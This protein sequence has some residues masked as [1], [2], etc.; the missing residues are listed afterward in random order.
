[1]HGK[2]RVSLREFW[3]PGSRR[4]GAVYGMY[5]LALVLF[6]AIIVFGFMRGTVG[7]DSVSLSTSGLYKTGVTSDG[8]T[9]RTSGYDTHYAV[10][11]V[12]NDGGYYPTCQTLSALPTPATIVKEYGGKAGTQSNNAHPWTAFGSASWISLDKNGNGREDSSTSCV[13][14]SDWTKKSICGNPVKVA[15]TKIACWAPTWN[16]WHYEATQKFSV[17]ANDNIDTSTVK[18]NIKGSV[19]NQLA[20]MINGVYLTT[21]S[22]AVIPMTDAA[23]GSSNWSDPNYHTGN[24]FT[25]DVPNNI[26]KIGQGAVNSIDFYVRSGYDLE[27]FVITDISL[28]ASTKPGG[29]PTNPPPATSDC[30]G[31]PTINTSTDVTVDLPD[32]TP[33]NSAA[34]SSATKP[35]ST[36]IQ[37][38]SE[39]TTTVTGVTDISSGGNPVGIPHKNDKYGQTT[40]DYS[41]YVSTYPYDK[42][43][44]QVTYDSYY[45]ETTWKSASTP[46]SSYYSC[47]ADAFS[48]GPGNEQY[49]H[50]HVSAKPDANG[51]C[52]DVYD[53]VAYNG[54]CLKRI[55]ATVNYLYDYSVVNTVKHKTQANTVSAYQMTAC[56]NREFTVNSVSALA[57]FSPNSENPSSA[58]S[59]ATADITFSVSH[60]GA[61]RTPYKLKNLPYVV[62]YTTN[63]GICSGGI[64]G[65]TNITTSSKDL[66]YE[67]PAAAIGSGS[68]AVTQPAPIGMTVTAIYSIPAAVSGTQVTGEMDQ[69]GNIQ[70]I[71]GYISGSA[72]TQPVYNAP[73]LQIYGG[74]AAAGTGFLSNGCSPNT[75]ATIKTFNQGAS[76]YRGAG[77]ELAA[78]A[79]GSID[80]FTT[81]QRSLVTGAAVPPPKTLSF[82]NDSAS[83]PYGGNYGNPGCS[84]DYAGSAPAATGSNALSGSVDLGSLD[85]G[86]YVA[87]GPL[88]LSG[89][90]G[91][92]KHVTIYSVPLASAPT[93][94]A[95]LVIIAGDIHYG[96]PGT[97]V[98]DMPSFSLIVK[99]NIDI[100]PSVSQL[101]GNY[102]AQG[103]TINDCKTSGDVYTNC[104]QKL[105]VHGSFLA[106]DIKFYRMGQYGSLRYSG[107][108]SG[109]GQN[110]A[111]EEFDYTPAN[112]LAQPPATSKPPTY[113]SVTSLPPVL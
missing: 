90:V 16:T 13:D 15:P 44:A 10:S 113:D 52:P 81:A 7:A 101:A 100:N 40:L 98:A 1:M 55:A 96:A 72:Q 93:Q 77:T 88:S 71:S 60:G 22:F 48:A 36:Y 83:G 3:Q 39:K 78:V 2:G 92:G 110:A 54:G 97:T 46:S 38:T 111:S 5:A 47:P 106:S 57:S 12:T 42:N 89:T 23:T 11:S 104:G 34:P 17:T 87:T 105:T 107:S 99:G 80:G 49:C 74:D 65:S 58:S 86:T 19:D 20:V 25:F 31:D 33:G 112:W 69:D 21:S 6:A 95:P 62:Q 103:G 37:D 64:S 45:T 18:L 73:Y 28:S 29:K 67:Y 43:Q 68:C 8:I 56:Y 102:I 51:N 41:N 82:A 61:L 24:T 76:P 35:N 14:P 4:R 30:P 63:Y 53:N 66:S 109:P 91:A 70:S 9:K 75:S 26:L 50:Q 85:N 108:D 84:A 94:P 27:G 32:K 59:S 79:G